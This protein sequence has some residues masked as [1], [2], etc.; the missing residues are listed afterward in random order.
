MLALFLINQQ[1]AN[2][3]NLVQSVLANSEQDFL[4]AY[5]GHMDM[6]MRELRSFK[7]KINSQKFELKKNRQIKNLEAER[8]YFK[9]EALHFHKENHEQQKHITEVHNENEGLRDDAYVLR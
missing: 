8:E 9:E 4:N 2:I 3:D 7:V 1:V 5:S 6:I